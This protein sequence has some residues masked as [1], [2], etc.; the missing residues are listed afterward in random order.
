MREKISLKKVLKALWLIYGVFSVFIV[1]YLVDQVICNG[2]KEASEKVILDNSWT[3]TMNGEVYENRKL[4]S[5]LFDSVNK[6]D[7]IVIETTIPDDI[8]YRNMLLCIQNPHTTVSMYVDEKLEYEYGYDRSK[9]NKATGSG[10]LF[11]DF[12]EEYK[13]KNLN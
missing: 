11:I 1:L 12:Y 6:G 5:F 4:D 2:L 3:I 13:G 10:Y 9:E 8:E 7:V